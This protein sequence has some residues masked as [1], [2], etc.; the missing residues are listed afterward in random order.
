MATVTSPAVAVSA[1]TPPVP[2][3]F[4]AITFHGRDESEPIVVPPSAHTLDGFREWA[5]SKDFPASG[6][7][8]FVNGDFLIDTSPERID[9][10]NFLKA[11]ISA[12]LAV[13]IKQAKLGYFFADRTLLSNLVAT[14]STEPDAMFISRESLSRGRAI[15]SPHGDRPQE[16]TELVGTPDW[17]LEIVS[18]SSKKKDKVLLR[19]AY[20]RAGVGEY[21]LVDALGEEIEF[22]ILVP[23]EK[24]YVAVAAEE[25]WLASPTFAKSFKLERAI[26]A[27]GFLEYTLHMR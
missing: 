7:L 20:F 9:T 4:S 10:H 14:I 23:G 16:A 2:V 18:P 26:D 5:L 22:Q 19:N 11:E 15:F 1:T 6:K 25:G 24:E 17:V 13:F 8:S 27:D 12:V 21:W 3:T